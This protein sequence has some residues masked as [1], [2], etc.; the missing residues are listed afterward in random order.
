MSETDWLNEVAE[1]LNGFYQED[2]HGDEMLCIDPGDGMG[3]NTYPVSEIIQLYKSRISPREA[4]DVIRQG[5]MP[6]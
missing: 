3:C 6:G 2:E 5:G 4:A 1:N